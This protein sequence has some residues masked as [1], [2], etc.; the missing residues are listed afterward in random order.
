MIILVTGGSGFIGSHIVDKL[1]EDG[2]KVR[3]LDIK[4]PHRSDVE[5]VKGDI[6]SFNAVKK[7]MRGVDIVYHIAA[8]SNINYVKDNPLKTIMLNIMGTANVLE[9][10]RQNKVKRVLLASSTY[11]YGA[12]GHLYT[13]T[14]K[15]SE[16]L[17]KDYFTLYGLSYTILRYST[18]YGPRSRGV[19]VIS[20]FV[21]RALEGNDLII[22]GDGKQNRN[23]IYVE[24]LAEGSVAALKKIAKNKTYDIIGKRKVS[25]KEVAETVKKTV[26]NNVTIKFD[27]SRFDDYKGEVGSLK[28]AKKELHWK[29]KTNLT[30]G[31]SKYMN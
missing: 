24:D 28:S 2:K 19:D 30:E 11:V 16:M 27:L 31:I 20:L 9:A 14:K 13:T 25:I 1:I 7:A 12:R 8:F 3:V 26:N 17:C 22:M 5:F 4:R 23:F 15:A 18:V 10:A 29:P 6:S 21:K